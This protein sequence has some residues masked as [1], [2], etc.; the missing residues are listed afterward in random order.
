[1]TIARLA[2][3]VASRFAVGL[4]SI[5]AVGATV[6]GGVYLVQRLGLEGMLRAAAACFM[7][8]VLPVGCYMAGRLMLDGDQVR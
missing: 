8:V 6:L 1:L 2:W 7:I 5:V 3:H 4:L